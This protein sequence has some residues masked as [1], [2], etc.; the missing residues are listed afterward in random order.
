MII[1]KTNLIN[2]TNM[3]TLHIVL[4]RLVILFVFFFIIKFIL[5]NNCEKR[6][7]NIKFI[8]NNVYFDRN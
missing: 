5:Q 7:R 3:A 8:K 1:T 6:K 4:S 2:F